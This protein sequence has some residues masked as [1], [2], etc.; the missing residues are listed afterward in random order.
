MRIYLLAAL[1]GVLL[2]SS[3]SLALDVTAVVPNRGTP[4]TLVA[5]YG[6]PFSPE[7][8]LFLGEEFVTLRVILENHMEFTIPELGP[9][10][11]ALTVQSDTVTAGQDYQFEVLSAAPE[12][13]SLEPRI[14]DSCRPD[15]QSPVQVIGRNFQP[16]ALLV[17]NQN[18]VPAQVVSPTLIEAQLTEFE[19]SGVYG[20]AVRNPD[21]ATSL[22][23][24]LW[25]KDVPE[26]ISVEQGENQVNY[27]QVIIH[28]KNFY[29]NSTLVVNEPAGRT[30][31]QS[32]QKLSFASRDN[33]L[34]HDIFKNEM[35]RL[36]YVDCQ[37]LIYHRYPSS[38]QD[39]DL[40]LQIFNPDGRKTDPYH[41]S[42]P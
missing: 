16:G 37:T 24:S 36:S 27:Y 19:Q 20:V 28:G 22:P 25:I 34:G 11:Y 15:N 38:F 9:G 42:L 5:V 31:G 10:S 35:T 7:T 17:V 2:V 21:G 30:I 26:I 1:L 18:A 32:H 13:T 23:H 3:Q 40:I 6:G 39:K 29:F 12:I 4:G 33:V 41:V 14:L 8:R